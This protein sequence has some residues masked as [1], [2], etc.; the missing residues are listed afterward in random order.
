MQAYGL[1]QPQDYA[2][3]TI[4]QDD[5]Y[6]PMTSSWT[7]EYMISGAGLIE[8]STTSSESIDIDLY[9]IHDS[10]GDGIP[11][12]SE[13]IASSAAPSADEQVSVILPDDGRYWVFV[14]GFGIPDG[15][16]TFDCTVNII[17]GNDLMVS[18]TPAGAIMADTP[19][20]FTV[21][22]TAPD[23]VGEY[24][25]MI[26]I[27]P[28]SAPEALSVPVTITTT[29][30]QPPIPPVPVPTLTPHGMVLMIVLLAVAG[31]V[32]LRRRE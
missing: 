31:S 12:P 15:T 6:N 9:L 13:M 7:C 30:T 21:T 22:Y 29:E 24:D 17:N 28:T 20:D 3:Q 32:A 19:C 14:H 25:G 11:E 23:M 1:S 16:S 10:D 18:D 2:D 5:P 26:F 27:G 8:V 4:M